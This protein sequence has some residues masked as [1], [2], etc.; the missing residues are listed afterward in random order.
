MLPNIGQ[1]IDIGLQ[2]IASNPAKAAITFFTMA[3]VRNVLITN[4]TDSQLEWLSKDIQT[5][6]LGFMDYLKSKEGRNEISR[7][8]DNYQK[9]VI[10]ETI[11]PKTITLSVAPEV[12]QNRKST[13]ELRPAA[14]R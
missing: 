4:L 7:I 12:V 2:Y 10:S 1:L 6:P 9:S 11:S 3:P 13:I 14:G 8:F 5:R